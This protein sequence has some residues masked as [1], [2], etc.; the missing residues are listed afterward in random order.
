MWQGMDLSVKLTCFRNVGQIPAKGL[1]D[2][3]HVEPHHAHLA[4][5]HEWS[6]N[7]QWF[8]HHCMQ[9]GGCV[10]H[11]RNDETGFYLWGIGIEPVCYRDVDEEIQ[12]PHFG[13]SFLQEIMDF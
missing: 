11:A 6:A 10:E 13:P 1:S 7:Q 9:S 12:Q 8:L 5:F 4:Y 3:F 2:A